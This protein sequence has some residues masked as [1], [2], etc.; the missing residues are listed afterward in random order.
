M[1]RDKK[2]LLP[3]SLLV[4]MFTVFTSP[5]AAG[6]KE[7]ESV[8]KHLKTKY[9][10]KKVKIPMIWLARFAVAMVRPAGVKSFSITTF[11]NLKFS[12]ETLNAE[13][14]M[15]LKN[16][17]SPDWSPIFRVRSRKGEQAYMYMREAG[18]SIKIMVVTINDNQ[19]SVIRAAFS[20]DKLA[21]F[22]NEPKI[23]G[24]S[25]DGNDQRADNKS[26]ESKE[27]TVTEQK[28]EELKKPN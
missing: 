16:S 17:F 12:R 24:I 7:Y 9:Q 13:M 14:Q 5:A 19:A 25:L 8:V 2:I 10:A 11:E 20:P 4:L 18:S 3:L 21:Q 1:F 15:A 27:N 22:M 6:G 28:T 26:A 23:F